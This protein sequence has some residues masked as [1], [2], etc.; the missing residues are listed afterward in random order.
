MRRFSCSVYLLENELILITRHNI[1]HSYEKLAIFLITIGY[2]V[3][4][5]FFFNYPY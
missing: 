5:Q 2:L 1:V 4:N 3:D